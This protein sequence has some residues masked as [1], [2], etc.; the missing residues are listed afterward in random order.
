MLEAAALPVDAWA[1][2]ARHG[3]DTASRLVA[4]ESVV[5]ERECMAPLRRSAAIFRRV[6]VSEGQKSDYPSLRLVQVSRQ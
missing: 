1:M 5:A 6:L 4:A 3:E 2:V